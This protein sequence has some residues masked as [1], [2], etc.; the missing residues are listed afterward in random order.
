M[1]KYCNHSWVLTDT[2]MSELYNGVD[3]DI[4]RYYTLTCLECNSVK[5]VDENEYYVMNKY[6]LMHER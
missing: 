6:G 5:E 1:S 2:R 4:I 3:Y